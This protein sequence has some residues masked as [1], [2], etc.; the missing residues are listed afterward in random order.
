MAMHAPTSPPVRIGETPDSAFRDAELEDWRF[1]SRGKWLVTHEVDTDG[2]LIAVRLYN[3]AT[4]RPKRFP[5]PDTDTDH[6]WRVHISDDD[7]SLVWCNVHAKWYILT[8]VLVV[9]IATGEERVI[10]LPKGC[11]ELHGR[12]FYRPGPWFFFEGGFRTVYRVRLD[13]TGMEQVFP[14]KRPVTEEELR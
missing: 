9:D 3:V 8:R 10:H 6:R 2:H 4:G 7:R 11:R 14:A 5:P 13:G 12:V 1:S